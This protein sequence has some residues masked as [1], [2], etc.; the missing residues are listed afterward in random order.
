MTPRVS[1]ILAM[2]LILGRYCMVSQ[3]ISEPTAPI[4]MAPNPF[5]KPAP[6]VI[7]VLQEHLPWLL[8]TSPPTNCDG[9]VRT[10][11]RVR[12]VQPDCVLPGSGSSDLIFLA[13][14]HWLSRD[15]RVLILDPTYGEYP[16]VLERVIGCRV[17]RLVLPRDRGYQLDLDQLAARFAEAIA[18]L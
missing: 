5:T 9:L 2:N 7:A 6:G 16:H 13:F 15:S 12:G 14:R 18:D 10:I 8:R 3:G 17:D 1:S 11:A 4:A